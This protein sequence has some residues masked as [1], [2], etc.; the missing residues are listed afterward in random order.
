[1]VVSGTCGNAVTNSA[2]LT[3]NQNVAVAIAP[4]SVTNCPGTTAGFN[5]SATGMGLSYQWYK[6][7]AVLVGQTGSSLV[8]ANVSAGDAGIYSVVVSGTCGSAVT[9]S[10]SLTV[11]QNVAVVGAPVSLTNCPGTS[12]SFGV[13]ATGTGL[14]YQWYQGGNA[15][16]GQTGNSLVLSSVSAADAGTYSAVISDVCGN[17]VTNSASLTVY[18]SVVVVSARVN[19]TNCLGSSAIF[20]V[21]ATGT[22]LGY[23]WYKGGS[24]LAGQ[25]SSRL[26]FGS[27]SASQAGDYSVVIRDVCGIAVTNSASLT[28]CVAPTISGAPRSLTLLVGQDAVFEVGATGTERLVYQWQFNGTNLVDATNATLVLRKVT[29][30]QAGAYGVTVTNL[31]GIAS[32]SATCSVYSTTAAVLKAPPSQTGGRFQFTITGVPGFN[33][34]LEASTDLVDWVP[35]S[36]NTSPFTFT[37][38]AA[39]NVPARYYRSV[40]LP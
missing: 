11:N 4:V 23:Q 2:S 36:T 14:S 27:V 6:G 37:D 30:G 9:N 25:T 16:A 20:S 24:A 22:G 13:D 33:Y 29:T 1:V 15:L 3:V 40:Y 12:A 7:S 10:A 31:A 34:A 26:I 21:N 28:V 18:P 5:V 35:L 39:T 17:T 32:T 19:L 8:L 38:D